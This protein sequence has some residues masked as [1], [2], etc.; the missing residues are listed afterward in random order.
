MS[1]L[2][3]PLTKELFKPAFDLAA[4][5]EVGTAELLPSARYLLYEFIQSQIL[6]VLSAHKF[7]AMT[8]RLM[9]TLADELDARLLLRRGL[10]HNAGH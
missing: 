1:G 7:G 10:L 8:Y 5:Q 2:S 6:E 3:S 4:E 9:K